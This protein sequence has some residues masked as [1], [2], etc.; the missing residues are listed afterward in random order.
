MQVRLRLDPPRPANGRWLGL[1]LAFP[2]AFIRRNDV[3]N[4]INFSIK[5]AAWTWGNEAMRAAVR[6][7]ACGNHSLQAQHMRAAAVPSKPA[8][9]RPVQRPQP[10][11]LLHLSP[12]PTIHSLWRGRGWSGIEHRLSQRAYSRAYSWP[13][14]VELSRHGLALHSRPYLA[15][16]GRRC[17]KCW[18]WLKPR[19]KP[20]KKH[21]QRLI[22]R[23][24]I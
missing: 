10:H 22:M 4:W 8:Q 16:V 20:G 15:A 21:G 23:P 14:R 1:G 18:F 9:A 17:C 5:H 12:P 24:A 11:S 6:H 3:Q 2:S 7:A 13:S 19:H